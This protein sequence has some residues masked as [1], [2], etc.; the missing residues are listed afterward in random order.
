MYYV[1]LEGMFDYCFLVIF[2]EYVG[3]KGKS[4]LNF[5]KI[6]FEVWNKLVRGI[7]LYV[8]VIKFRSLKKDFLKLN[9]DFFFEIE[10]KYDIKRIQLNELKKIMYEDFINRI[11]Q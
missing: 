9:K 1:Y 5:F 8:I 7:K 4:F 2:F 10:K 11:I 3:V 6:V